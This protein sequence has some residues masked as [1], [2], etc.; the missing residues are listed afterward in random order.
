MST[1]NRLVM[2][3]LGSQQVISKKFPDHWDSCSFRLMIL[4]PT[5]TYLCNQGRPHVWIYVQGC[6]K[7]MLYICVVDIIAGFWRI[8]KPAVPPYA[9]RLVPLLWHGLTL[10]HLWG[11]Y[12]LGLSKQR[13]R[14]KHWLK[15]EPPWMHEKP[16]FKTKKKKSIKRRGK[17]KHK[18]RLRFEVTF[19]LYGM[20]LSK[21]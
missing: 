3:T 6:I 4:Y 12:I 10:N 16:V 11:P 14:Y 13:N 1:C 9:T 7:W 2:Q 15:M 5:P 18:K 20:G 21:Q 17:K 19:P 8:W